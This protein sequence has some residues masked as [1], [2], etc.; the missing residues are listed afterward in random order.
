MTSPTQQHQAPVRPVVALPAAVSAEEARVKVA[1][2]LPKATELDATLYH[3]PFLGLVFECTSNRVRIPFRKNTEPAVP[4]VAYLIVDMVG[5][6]AY[7]GDPWDEG[8]FVPIPQAESAVVLGPE[9]RIEE[10][11]AIRSARAVLAG[12]MA[13]RRRIDTINRAD[14][15]VPPLRFGKPNWWVTGRRGERN[16]EVIVDAITGR[17]Y[18]CSA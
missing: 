12:V 5:G 17:H 10:A 8:S 2:R 7:L 14:L 3:H 13:R 16:V 6:S 11:V 9:A 18:A 4:E 15:L 1:R